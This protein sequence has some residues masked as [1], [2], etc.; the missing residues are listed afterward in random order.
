MAE[1][2]KEIGTAFRV[3]KPFYP[4]NLIS[5]AQAQVLFCT[6]SRQ[7]LLATNLTDASRLEGVRVYGAQS[8][9]SLAARK[10]IRL[11]DRT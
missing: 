2:A 3:L 7:P 8:Q 1:P 4:T 11:D 9:I 6:T 10:H 5:I